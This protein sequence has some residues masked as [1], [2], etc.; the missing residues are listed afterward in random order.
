VTNK[1]L[2]ELKFT[3]F[4]ME[5][6]NLKYDQRKELRDAKGA[7]KE[8]KNKTKPAHRQRKSWGS[9]KFARKRK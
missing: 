6:S 8:Q 1:S 7:A 2:S 5:K 9:K 4:I 3:S